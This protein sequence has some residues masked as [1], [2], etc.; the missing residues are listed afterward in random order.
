MFSG[1][2]TV[3]DDV[4]LNLDMHIYTFVLTSDKVKN[5]AAEYAIPL[6]LRPCVPP[7][8]LTMNMLPID[9]IGTALMANEVIPQHTTQPLPSGSQIPEKSNHQKVVE[10]ENEKVFA[11]KRKARAAKDRATLPHSQHLNPSNEDTHVHSGGDKLRHNVREEPTYT[12]ASGSTSHG[13]SSS[14]GGLHRQAFLR[15]NPGGDGICSFPPL[16]NYSQVHLGCIKKEADLA[17]NLIAVEKERDDL[18]D[19]NRERE[20][21]MKQLEAD[22]ASKTSS[23]TEAE[24]AASILKEGVK[25]AC[26][27]EYAKAFL[28]TDYDPECK[29]TFMYTFDSIFTK[30]YPMQDVSDE[31]KRQWPSDVFCPE[32][33]TLWMSPTA[34]GQTASQ[35][36]LMSSQHSGL[37]S[38]IRLHAKLPSLLAEQST[39]RKEVGAI[40]EEEEEDN[41]MAPI[42]RCLADGV[43]PEDR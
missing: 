21:Q 34:N 28:A 26:S 32:R 25:A 35:A 27:E 39:D 30:I 40:V 31:S 18:L 8:S 10:Y 9:K 4:V 2:Q 24:S 16:L 17:E 14:S 11:V 22:L 29:T 41:W 1:S 36:I 7:S 38:S 19:Q 15:H 6:Y 13:V 33:K 37:G 20:E 23:L 42:I 12:H 3:G 5:L 43:W